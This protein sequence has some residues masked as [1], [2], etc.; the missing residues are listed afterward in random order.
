MSVSVRRDDC[1]SWQPPARWPRDGLAPVLHRTKVSAVTTI[2]GRVPAARYVSMHPLVASPNFRRLFVGDVLVKV[3]ERYFALTVAWWLLAGPHASGGRLGFLLMLESLPILLVGA[4]SGPLIERSSKKRCMVASASIQCAIVA[5]VAGLLAV[6]ALSFPR[7]VAA[8]IALGSLIPVFEGAAAAALPLAVTARQLP[9]AAALQSMTV[10][11]SNVIA[12]ALAAIVLATG[13]FVTALAVDAAL[14][15]VAALFLLRLRAPAFSPSPIVRSYVADLR[16]GLAHLLNRRPLAAFVGIYIAELFLFVP[17]LVLIPMLV[18]ATR[19]GG[20]G[21]VAILETSFSLGAIATAL[22]LSTG[23][24]T[25]RLYR[26]SMLALVLL[27]ASMLALTRLPTLMAMIP[28]VA[29]MGACVAVLVGLANVLFQQVVPD[30]LKGRFFG[31]VETLGAAA[32]PLG[33]ALVGL[34][35]GWNGVAGVVVVT[36]TG[37]LVLAACVFRAPRVVM[38]RVRYGVAADGLRSES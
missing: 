2:G 11:F 23:D 22:A 7:L 9:G 5:I 38:A 35:F 29:I 14:Y 32:T 3:A 18:Q 33:Y 10:E 15:G 34:A 28:A 12:A 24:A 19:G 6:D 17:L 25:Q 1:G 13:G 36:A 20:V 26:R 8:A 27:A 21:W 4:L 30:H 16:A 37:L 31:I